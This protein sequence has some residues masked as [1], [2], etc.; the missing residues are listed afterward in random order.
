MNE[1]VV[2]V[3]YLIGMF[4]VLGISG[5]GMAYTWKRL[6]V[7]GAKSLFMV[8]FLLFAFAFIFMMSLFTRTPEGMKNIMLMAHAMILM[9]PFPWTGMV[10]EMSNRDAKNMWHFMLP[11]TI[12]NGAGFLH[13]VSPLENMG[14]PLQYTNCSLLGFINRCEIGH[15]WLYYTVMGI[16]LFEILGANGFLIYY[17]SQPKQVTERTRYMLLVIA[18]TIGSILL[19][20]IGVVIT[21]PGGLDPLPIGI[22]ILA[23]L[24][25]HAIFNKGLMVTKVGGVEG[26]RTVDDIYL[27]VDSDHFI[28]DVNLATLQVFEMELS[29][30]LNVQ[31]EHAFI[32]FP[33]IVNLFSHGLRS[34]TLDLPISGELHTFAPVLSD[35]IDPQTNTK[36]GQQLV[37]KDIT[38]QELEISSSRQLVSLDPLTR[39]YDRETFFRLGEKII[40]T[41]QR[42]QQ[43]AALAMINIDDFQQVNQRFS[44]LVG[45]QVLLELVEIIN[46]IIRQSDLFA[47]FE[48]DNLA[49]LLPKADEFSAYQICARMKDA[50]AG[51]KFTFRNQEFQVTVSIGYTSFDGKQDNTN[52]LKDL[53][54]FAQKALGQSQAL[55]RNRLTFL[56]AIDQTGS[57]FTNLAAE[58]E[59]NV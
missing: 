11:W 58:G 47:R 48:G 50:I 13:F 7:R 31:L 41:N 54:G 38:T 12:I 52:S 4:V 3:L 15:S 55:G 29:D 1:T 18:M 8:L 37:M 14:Q 28:Q 34:E 42:L 32:E 24:L 22:G 20:L 40:A 9:I 43:T 2:S 57:F 6:E 33:E 35:Y 39:Q 10:Y 59:R 36:A 44:H 21:L 23:A 53:M 30:I 5:F 26:V 25:F 46:S 51:H 49:I 16:L 45:D 27:V 19:F 17:L 56:P